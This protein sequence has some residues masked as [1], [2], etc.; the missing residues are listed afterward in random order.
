MPKGECVFMNRFLRP[1]EVSE[2]VGLGIASIYRLQK[3]GKF[4][5][6]RRLSP[7]AVGILES[8]LREFLES[9][10]FTTDEQK[11]GNGDSNS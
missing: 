5:R 4:P 2:I 3:E 1:R 7:K 9:R 6:M 8:E 11:E 10:P